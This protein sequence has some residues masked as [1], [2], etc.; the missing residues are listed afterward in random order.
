MIAGKTKRLDRGIDWMYAGGVGGPQYEEEERKKES[1]EYLLGKE[2]NPNHAAAASGDFNLSGAA[3]RTV[4]NVVSAPP[5]PP[6]PKEEEEEEAPNTNT[7]EHRNESFHL[8]HEDP[9]FLVH[10]KQNQL[11]TKNEKKM[12]LFSRVVG[13]DSF[14]TKRRDES[15]NDYLRE[16]EYKRKKK[17][18]KKKYSSSR[19]KRRSYSSEEEDESHDA[20]KR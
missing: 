9:M 19:D 13:H 3:G 16:K 1:E 18:K 15:E 8:R 12:E 10:Q 4:E 6:L 7:V 20:R 11:Q 2:F 14:H 5:P 17:K